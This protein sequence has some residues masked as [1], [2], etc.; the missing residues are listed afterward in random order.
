MCKKSFVSILYFLIELE[1]K[2]VLTWP[3]QSIAT[4][5]GLLTSRVFYFIPSY[6]KSFFFFFFNEKGNIILRVCWEHQRSSPKSK[7]H[8]E[9]YVRPNR[10]FKIVPTYTVLVEQI[11]IYW[12][13]TFTLATMLELLQSWI[14]EA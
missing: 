13:S 10:V 5:W 2:M 11:Q 12:K 7:I 4:T 9:E 1:I 6:Y 14:K 8:R 3:I